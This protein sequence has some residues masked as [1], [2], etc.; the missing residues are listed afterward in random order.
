MLMRQAGQGN[1]LS[2]GKRK[3]YQESIS[4]NSDYDINKPS[5]NMHKNFMQKRKFTKEDA[6]KVK[7]L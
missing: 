5:I 1:G 6:N 3:P 2:E 7:S 4:L